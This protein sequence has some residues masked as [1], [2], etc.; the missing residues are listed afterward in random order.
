MFDTREYEVWYTGGS[1]DILTTNTIVANMFACVDSEGQDNA[2][3]KEIVA[4]QK[5]NSV[6]EVKD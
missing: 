1:I 2:M 4:H 3:L 6:M 5:N